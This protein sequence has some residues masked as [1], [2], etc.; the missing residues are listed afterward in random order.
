LRID[1]KAIIGCVGDGWQPIVAGL[2]KHIKFILKRYGLD[3]ELLNVAQVK[4]K[5]GGLRFYWCWN[6]TEDPHVKRI[7]DIA[8]E[9]IRDLVRAAEIQCDQTCEYCG[10]S[11]EL[12]DTQ[13]WIKVR[14]PEC[15]AKKRNWRD[16]EDDNLFCSD[17]RGEE[18]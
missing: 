9:D 11:G 12:D 5:L 10:E 6:S 2:C 16:D 7:Q 13:S 15:K 1:D 17:A 8:H 18:K 3:I 14:C 4:E